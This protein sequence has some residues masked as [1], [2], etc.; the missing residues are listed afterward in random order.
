[1]VVKSGGFG[2]PSSYWTPGAEPHD[3]DVDFLMELRNF[4]VRAAPRAAFALR[5]AFIKSQDLDERRLLAVA[6]LSQMV[7][8]FEL[9]AILMLS[10]RDRS[11]RSLLV[12]FLEHDP[13]E[14]AEA[15]EELATVTNESDVARFARLPDVRNLNLAMVCSSALSTSRAAGNTLTSAQEAV[16]VFH[17]KAKHGFLVV[18]AFDQHTRPHF[19]P[20]QDERVVA[21]AQEKK[22][23]PVTRRRAP[24][25]LSMATDAA[26][27][28]RDAWSTE[29]TSRNTSQVIEF[30]LAAIQD[31]SL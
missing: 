10:V 4:G 16:R 21:L 27:V 23:D 17:N 9:F 5:D 18:R 26:S 1:M 2:F 24:R 22:R 11:R 7:Q 6:V 25:V 13:N 30:I 31:R 28:E 12:T 19:G 15:L 8:A 29:M 14:L 20:S 3:Q